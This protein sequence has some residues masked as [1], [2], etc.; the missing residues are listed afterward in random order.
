MYLDMFRP[1]HAFFFLLD[2]S[3]ASSSTSAAILCS[4]EAL[5]MGTREASSSTDNYRLVFVHSAMVLRYIMRV[6]SGCPYCWGLGQT[7]GNAVF[8]LVSVRFL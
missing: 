4:C 7:N 8:S 3:F 5:N 6:S 2:V 1:S